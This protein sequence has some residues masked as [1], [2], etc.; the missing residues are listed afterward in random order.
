MKQDMAGTLCRGHLGDYENI[1]LFIV[2]V[3]LVQGAAVLLVPI[4]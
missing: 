1:Y 4:K 2:L 3:L